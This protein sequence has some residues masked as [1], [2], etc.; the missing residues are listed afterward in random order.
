MKYLRYHLIIVISL[1]LVAC[2]E[3]D[4]LTVQ[5]QDSVERGAVLRTISNDPNSFTFDD[6]DSEWSLT[7][8]HQDNDGSSQKQ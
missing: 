5:I 7:I 1:V 2:S 4:K 6:P 8:E 3:D